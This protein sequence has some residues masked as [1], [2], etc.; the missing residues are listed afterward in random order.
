MTVDRQTLTGLEKHHNQSYQLEQEFV[1]H[2]DC[3]WRS[4]EYS[5]VSDFLW[6]TNW[7]GM[8]GCGRAGGA[9]MCDIAGPIFLMVPQ[10]KPYMD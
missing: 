9:G 2:V 5:V 6:S 10:L 3:V 7:E 4:Y 8:V 1:Y